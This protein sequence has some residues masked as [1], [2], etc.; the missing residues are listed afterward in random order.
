MQDLLSAPL[1]AAL[2]NW[3]IAQY[4]GISIWFPI[5][6]TLHVLTV[7]LLLAA[8]LMVDLRLLGLA[9]AR[10]SISALTAD[11]FGWAWA[12]F[13]LACISGLAMFITRAA[14]HIHNPAFGW[15]M[16]LLLLAGINMAYF[17]LLLRPQ[18]AHWDSAEYPPLVVRICG[19]LSLLLWTGTIIA[20]RWIGHIS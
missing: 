20:G 17:Q 11:F 8:I 6:E 7:C 19:G 10:Y 14:T 3:P 5:I 4:I 15:K 1:W 12:G 9:G 13:V 18:I 16:L 2:E